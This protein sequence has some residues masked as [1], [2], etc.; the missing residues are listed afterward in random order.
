MRVK[1][2]RGKRERARIEGAGHRNHRLQKNQIQP[3]YEEFRKGMARNRHYNI[4]ALILNEMQKNMG[5]HD[6]HN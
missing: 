2:M 3:T 4:E 6:N 5:P 1:G